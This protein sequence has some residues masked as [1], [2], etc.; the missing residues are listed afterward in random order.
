MSWIQ[1]MFF[2]DSLHRER[3]AALL[4]D[5]IMQ[6]A[7]DPELFCDGAIRD[8]LTGRFQAVALFSALMLPRLTS[9]GHDGRRVSDRVY[10]IIFDSFDSALRETGVGD[11]SIAR[12]VR[13]MGEE[14]FGIGTAVQ[15]ALKGES[16][17]ADLEIL[18]LRNKVVQQAY[19]APQ[20]VSKL[21]EAQSRLEHAPDADLMAG[22]TRW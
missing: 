16:P 14:F 6:K 12:K 8:E 17:E 20:L 2:P 1:R 5:S 7:R 13:A 22:K 10:R 4:F 3:A 18:L 9:I 19:A 11:A 15:A 21:L